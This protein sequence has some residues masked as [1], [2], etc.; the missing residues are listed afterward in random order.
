MPDIKDIYNNDWMVQLRGKLIRSLV[1]RK[2]V[3]S[4]EIMFTLSVE[5]WINYYRWHSFEDKEPE[6]LDWIDSHLR[7]GD[8]FFDVGSIMD[9][10]TMRSILLIF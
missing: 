3:K 10:H 5:N 9:I 1:P 2:K 7:S 6:T 8:I 4:R